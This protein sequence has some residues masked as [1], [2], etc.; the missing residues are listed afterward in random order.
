MVYFTDQELIR[1]DAQFAEK[2]IPFH[3]RPLAAAE[4]I[5]QTG[6]NFHDPRLKAICDAYEKLFPEARSTWPGMGAGMVASVDRVRAVTTSVIFG[7]VNLTPSSGLGFSDDL[8]WINWCRGERKIQI[9]ST[10]AFADIYDFAYALGDLRHHEDTKAFTLWRNAAAQLAT[11]ASHLASSGNPGDAVLQNIGL[12]AELAI[13]GSLLHVGMKE[14]ELSYKPYGHN[15]V[16]LAERLIELRPHRDDP[17]L[18]HCLQ[19]L[20]DYVQSRY[21]SSNLSRLQII[22]LALGTQFVAA[23]A[24]RRIAIQDIAV[25]VEQHFGPRARYFN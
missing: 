1:L 14:K 22:Q 19:Q 6:F 25:Q 15:Y 8:E 11:T 7:Q 4:A 17:V 5:L 24:V 16:A 18:L 10:F 9:Q 23:S 3:A 2:N 20:P 13:K 21:N 12:T